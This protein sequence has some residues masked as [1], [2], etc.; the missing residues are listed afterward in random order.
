MI[1]A[2]TSIV[3]GA[4]G[5]TGKYITRLLLER[6]QRVVG[7]TGHPD[8][9][10][11]FGDRVRVAAFDFDRPEQLART[12]CGATTLYNTYWV[13]FSHR[14]TTFERAVENTKTLL[15]A[16]EAAGVQRVVHVSITNPSL[17]SSLAYFRGKAE[18]EDFIR[19]SRLSHAILRPTVLFGREDILINN[20]AWLLRRMPVF[21]VPGR[22]EY[23]LQPV[24]VEDMAELAVAAGERDDDVTMDAVGPEAYSFIELVRMIAAAV[25]SRTKLLCAPPSLALWCSRAIGLLTRDVVL[26]RDEVSG[27][28]ADLLV[29]D[30]P[31]TCS[32]KL[33]DWV[34]E[35]AGALGTEYHSELG[36]HYRK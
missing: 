11:P 8:R 25:G 12:M 1:D 23:R 21:L 22:G 16:A 26:T 28:A 14:R 36:R 34:R 29:S 30:D 32:T 17:D 9:P 19:A 6:G 2:Q 35:N 20:I 18:L 33:S 7:L 31:P 27:L 3:T 13:R 10:S 24:Y 15:R 4:A 5:Y